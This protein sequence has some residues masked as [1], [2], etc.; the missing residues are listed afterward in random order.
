M[1]KRLVPAIHVLGCA[2]DAFVAIYTVGKHI[3]LAHPVVPVT[4]SAFGGHSFC[5][6]VNEGVVHAQWLEDVFCHEVAVAHAGDFF[7]DA[8]EDGEV[9]VAVFEAGIW[10][11][12]EAWH[13]L[14]HHGYH[15]FIVDGRVVVVVI[16]FIPLGVVGQA[17]AVAEEHTDS[18]VGV[19]EFF[20]VGLYGRVEVDVFMLVEVECGGAGKCFGY[21]R[22]LAGGVGAKGYAALPV[23]IAEVALVKYLAACAQQHAPVEAC[24]HLAAVIG[25][26]PGYE[27]ADLG[28]GGI[29]H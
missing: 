10:A 26:E 19:G 1:V 20:D 9:G 3:G 21:G 25:I 18:D 29:I 7:D 12:L 27:V 16:Y 8:G 15:G 22:K 11:E 24:G 28:A 5:G 6:V 17:G 23:A 2:V 14:R 4:D 13:V